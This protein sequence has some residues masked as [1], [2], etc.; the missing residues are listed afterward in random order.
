MTAGV[1][2]EAVVV[3]SLLIPALVSLF[4]DAGAWPSR[5]RRGVPT[6]AEPSAGVSSSSARTSR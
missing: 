6:A 5:F 3:R 2:L 4:G 1:L